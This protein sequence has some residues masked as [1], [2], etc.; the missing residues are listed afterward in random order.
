MT[1]VTQPRD[2]NLSP[3][4]NPVI[5]RASSGTI[6]WMGIGFL[7]FTVILFYLLITTW[8]VAEFKE[9]AD[10]IKSF[11]SFNIFGMP[12]SWEHDQKMLFPVMMAGALRSLPPTLA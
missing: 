4:R 9:S 8:P 1:G 5:D 7:V 11:K 6:Y 12:C 2:P 3:S 10:S